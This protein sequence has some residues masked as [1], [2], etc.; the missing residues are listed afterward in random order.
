MAGSPETIFER[1][2]PHDL[3]RFHAQ[4]RPSCGMAPDDLRR[5]NV[6]NR[7]RFRSRMQPRQPV[8]SG[9]RT[10]GT[11]RKSSGFIQGHFGGAGH[12]SISLPAMMPVQPQTLLV[13]TIKTRSLPLSRR[14]EARPSRLFEARVFARNFGR[15]RAR[16]PRADCRETTAGCHRE[17]AQDRGQSQQEGQSHFQDSYILSKS[18]GL[19]ERA[20]VPGGP[21]KLIRSK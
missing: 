17:L 9:D 20:P 10:C 19:S 12:C 3:D 5:R 15:T 4:A 13:G 8:R 11:G 18:L 16:S 2:V 7:T 14:V 21:Q 6:D 1:R